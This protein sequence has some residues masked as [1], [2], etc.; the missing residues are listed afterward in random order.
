M[1]CY[2]YE[3]RIIMIIIINLIYIAHFDTNGILTALYSYRVHT[4][5]IYTCM[6]IHETIMFILIY[7]STH[8]YVH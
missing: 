2:L 6:D 5:T 4:N 1:E 8:I 7:M 3:I